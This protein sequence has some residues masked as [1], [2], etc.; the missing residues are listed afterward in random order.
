MMMDNVDIAQL[1]QL[2]V[3]PIFLL[4][5]TGSFLNVM[6]VR[7]GRIVD[8]G[9][10]LETMIEETEISAARKA[11][12]VAELVVLEDRLRHTNRA[13]T[14]CT[15]AALLTCLEVAMLFLRGLVDLPFAG[16]AAALFTG[17][18]VCLILGLMSFLREVA[19]ATSSLH[20]GMRAVE[21]QSP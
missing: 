7:L 6:T 8:R 18:M 21:E 13:V 11:R 9:R 17:A 12:Y 20:V 14:L 16:A 19:L 1:I 4:V 10:S 15:V 5:G 2:S 3:A